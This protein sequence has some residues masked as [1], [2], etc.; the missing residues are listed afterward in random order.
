MIPQCLAS[1]FRQRTD[2]ITEER[3]QTTHDLH[4]LGAIGTNLINS[5]AQKILP[6]RYLTDQNQGGG[7]VA[8]FSDIQATP[9]EAISAAPRGGGGSRPGALITT[10]PATATSHPSHCWIVGRSPRRR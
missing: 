2:Q 4:A 10:R 9:A 3:L 7:G 6:C 5:E 1:F 8:D